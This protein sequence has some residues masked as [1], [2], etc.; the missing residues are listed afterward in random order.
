MR[1]PVQPG[2]FL[3]LTGGNPETKP[4]LSQGL[5]E[6]RSL[7]AQAQPRFAAPAVLPAPLQWP[8]CVFPPPTERPWGHPMQK[9][10]MALPRG[11]WTPFASLPGPIRVPPSP[12]AH[13]LP[14]TPPGSSTD[15]YFII[16]LPEKGVGDVAGNAGASH[17]SWRKDAAAPWGRNDVK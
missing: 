7:A 13:Q 15:K 6:P 16:P 4:W 2:G 1:P 12:A 3:S 17:N 5:G 9:G 11:P 10:G 8:S 14:Q